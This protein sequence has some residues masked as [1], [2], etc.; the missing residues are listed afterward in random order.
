MLKL[1]VYASFID[2]IQLTLRLLLRFPSSIIH[3]T[4][5]IKL[6]VQ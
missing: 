6:T 3:Q 5:D 1:T 2:E 4:T